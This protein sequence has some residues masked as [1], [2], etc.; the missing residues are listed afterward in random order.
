MRGRPLVNLRAIVMTEIMKKISITQHFLNPKLAYMLLFFSAFPYLTFG[1]SPTP[2]AYLQPF[3]LIVAIILI[4]LNAD[5]IPLLVLREEW[6]SFLMSFFGAAFILIVSIFKHKTQYFS[7]AYLS[8]FIFIV[9]VVAYRFVLQQY[10]SLK[11]LSRII[12]YVICIYFLVG[13]I[14]LFINPSFL[15]F[16]VGGHKTGVFPN[17]GGTR[18]VISL[19]SEPTYYACYMLG[20]SAVL[21]AITS[22][23]K[24]AMFLIIVLIQVFLIAKSSTAVAVAL[25]AGFICLVSFRR[26]NILLISSVVVLFVFFIAYHVLPDTL[27]IHILMDRLLEL[28][29]SYFLFGDE[30][31]AVRIM[32]AIFPFIYAFKNYM[33]PMVLFDQTW[34]QYLKSFDLIWFKNTPEGSRIISGYGEILVIYGFFVLPMVRCVIKSLLVI[35]KEIQQNYFAVCIFLLLFTSFSFATPV[36]AIIYVLYNANI[37]TMQSN[38]ISAN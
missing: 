29:I 26:N 18:G 20:L 30:S 28:D 24:S 4:A 25:V 13:L 10:V 7:A 11:E 34:V 21:T 3:F 38:Y 9:L 6:V 23:K 16:L 12:K 22:G 32:N 35:Q 37:K 5:K 31:T 15:V 14:Q 1:I 17:V 27:R 2:A 8:P 36:V 19:S 33:L